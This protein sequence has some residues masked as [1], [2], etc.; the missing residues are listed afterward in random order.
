MPR[1]EKRFELDLDAGT[2]AAY[3]SDPGNVGKLLPFISETNEKGEWIIKDQQ[4]KVV[5]TKK[6]VPVLTVKPGGALE[7]VGKGEK[8]TAVLAIE[9]EGKER[10]SLVRTTLAMDVD[11]ALGAVLSPIISL[12]IRN[13]LD[14]F[15]SNLREQF[16]EHARVHSDCRECPL[17]GH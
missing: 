8:L 16:H 17:C 9:I 3:L 1:S 11:G 4:S 5:Q 12:N 2:L 13:Q 7:W 15:V 10:G 6:L 14:A